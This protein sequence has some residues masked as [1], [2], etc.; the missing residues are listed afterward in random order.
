MSNKEKFKLILEV[1]EGLNDDELLTVH[2]EY[3][4]ETNGY[5]DEI[6]TLD[7]LDMIAEGQDSYWLLCRAF[8]GNFNPMADYFKFNG[9]GNIQ[10]IFSCEL[11]DYIDMKDIARYC[12]D[13]GKALYND[14]IQEILKSENEE[15]EEA[16][17]VII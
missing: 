6:Y 8:Y 14:E 15:A 7:D 13:N 2:R 5:D 11:T 1:L 3:L 10:S 9:Y 17:K 4:S 16:E 12:V